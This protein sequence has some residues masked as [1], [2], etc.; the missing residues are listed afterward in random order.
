VLGFPGIFRSALDVRARDI[1]QEM[2]LAAAHSIASLVSDDE[3]SEDYIIT[4]PTDP[5]VMVEEARAV[6]KAA[7]ES[8][9]ARNKVKPAWVA[10]HT[11]QLIEYYR[12][13][14][15]PLNEKRK[16]FAEPKIN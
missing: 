13:C 5:R 8:G 16:G 3:L 11:R 15:D 2:N 7:I 4:N 12:K 1:N 9:V 14:I 6:A 10:E